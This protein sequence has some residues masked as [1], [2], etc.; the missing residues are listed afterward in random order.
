M[1]PVPLLSRSPSGQ[2][3]FRFGAGTA[4]VAGVWGV[5]VSIFSGV[6]D[7][8]YALFAIMLMI[9]GILLWVQTTR[10]DV[11]QQKADELNASE[12][13]LR[14]VSHFRQHFLSNMS[15]E[16][17]TPLNAIQGF[18]QSILHRQHEMSPEQVA[19]Y[20]RIIDKSAQDMASLTDNVLDLSRLD[21]SNFELSLSEVDFTRLVSRAVGRYTA[22]AAERNIT[23]S[24]EIGEDWLLRC[25]GRGIRRCLDSLISN[26]LNFSD[27]GQHIDIRAR[28]AGRRSF[29]VEVSDQGCGISAEDL[30][31][32]WMV[33][34]RSSTTKKSG[35]IG[36]GLG[37]AV[38]RSLVEA[39]GGYIEI[40]SKP[41]RG[42]TVRLCF[43]NT[44]IVASDNPSRMIE[45]PG[46][47]AI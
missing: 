17:R 12:L 21:A 6:P 2:N 30:K 26:A 7:W 45:L 5:F 38:T 37:L 33:Y 35:R 9:V 47:V 39:H 34:A 23:M 41:D 22:L 8:H 42:T 32:I 20:L 25:D 31:T 40:V 29:V 44:M 14:Q 15:H 19:D 1:P 27:D 24:Y 10:M 18:A 13:R 4:V 3:A 16:F 28:L 36:A 46:G 11:L 43:P